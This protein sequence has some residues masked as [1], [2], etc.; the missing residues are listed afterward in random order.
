M[1]SKVG[2]Q[3]VIIPFFSGLP[4]M[5]WMFRFSMHGICGR[6]RRERNFPDMKL[7][8]EPKSMRALAVIDGVAEVT[9]TVVYINEVMKGCIWTALQ[10]RLDTRVS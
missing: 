4:M 6:R 9:G 1:E 7:P 5:E 8:T 10:S 2:E 3:C